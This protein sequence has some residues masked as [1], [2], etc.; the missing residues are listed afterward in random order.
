MMM[1]ASRCDVQIVLYA[2]QYSPH[3]CRAWS[4]CAECSAHIQTCMVSAAADASYA[5]ALAGSN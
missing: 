3:A 1:A 5:L 2:V 4:H